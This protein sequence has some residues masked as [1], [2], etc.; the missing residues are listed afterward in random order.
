[1]TPRP[2]LI[3]LVVAVSAMLLV[4]P[5]APAD[6]HARKQATRKG[7]AAPHRA[8]AKRRA[9]KR[10][11]LSRTA[12]RRTSDHRAPFVADAA[13]TPMTAPAAL[14]PDD[15]LAPLGNDP[16]SPPK[17]NSQKVTVKRDH[18]KRITLTGDDADG[19]QFLEFAITKAPAHGTLSGAPPEVVYT[20][21]AGYLGPDHFVFK[22]SDGQGLSNS[23][24]VTITVVPLGAAPIVTTSAGCTAYTE[25]GPS[26]VVDGQVTVSDP[27]DVLLD[28]ARVRITTGFQGGDNLLFTDQNGIISSYD[29]NAGVLTLSGDATVAAYQAALSTVRYRNVAS[30]NANATKDVEFTVNDAGNDSAPAVKQVCVTGGAGGS[31]NRPVG[32]TSEGGLSYLENDGPLP[33]DSGFVVGDPDSTT[34]SGATVKFVPLVSQAVDEN[35][36]PVGPP[37]STATFAPGEDELAFVDQNGITGVYD[38]GTGLLTLSGP[39]S[40]ADYETA[41]RSV[42]YENSSEDPSDATRRIQFQL[43]DSSALNSTSVRRDVFITPVNDAP[44]VTT[45]AGVTDYTGSATAVDTG[46]TAIDVDD[47]DLESA[48]VRITSGLQDGDELAVAAPAG[49]ADAYD[50]TTGVLTLSGTASV[51]DYQTALRSIAFGHTGGDPSGARTV[52]YTI[53]DGELDSGTA[54]KDV[55]VNDPPVLATTSVDAVAY[56]ENDPAVAVDPGLTAADVDSPQLAGA[57]VAISS[58]FAAGEDVLAFADLGGITGAYDD[59][60]GVLTLSGAASP[61]DYA[62]A[63]QSV[64]YENSSEDPSGATRTVTFR[65]DDGAVFNSLSN[66]VTR[67][68]AVTPVN[69]AP[70]VVTSDG[71]TAA[72]EGD[73][74]VAVDGALTV[75]DVDSTSLESAQVSV[76]SALQAGDELSFTDQNGITGVY[77]SGVLSLSGTASVADYEAALRSVGYAHT[78]DDPVASKT[79]DFTAGDGEVSSSP[80]TKEL[81]VTGV[82]DKPSLD[83]SDT[84]LAYIGGDGAVAVDDAIAATDPDS[85]QLG[86]ATV[87]I[88]ANF[89]AAEDTLAFTDQNGITSAYDSTTGVLTLTGPASVAQFQAA[90]R[91]VTYENSSATPTTDTRTVSFQVD[92]G[93]A[94]DNL[95]DAA[96]RDVSVSAGNG[97]L[98]P[99]VTSSAGTT[100]YTIGDPPTALDAGVTVTDAD[101]AN[102]ESAVVRVATGFEAGDTLIFVAQAGITGLYDPLTGILTLSGTA[103]VAEYETALRSITYSYTGENPSGSRTVETK[104]NDG[105][106]NSNAGLRA[107]EINSPAG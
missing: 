54:S 59:T 106:R 4:P 1:M 55:E 23:G 88:T 66:E 83:T 37:T 69:D 32:E 71:S 31:A 11:T 39:A 12:K 107:L 92:D 96:T 43:T 57:T 102:L 33:V 27:D 62:L 90:L 6:T 58:G 73:P 78:G 2:T 48:V 97:D 9:H 72:T 45:S 13:A 67:D 34:L 70:Q 30:G 98:R 65:V 89:V 44:V 99:V 28:S 85:A 10:H 104:V 80:A 42:T 49:V 60:T 95:S 16:N 17:A 5:A 19:A 56:T 53:N 74:A 93:A 46:L 51:A 14:A 8:K 21:D 63:L 38:D 105:D 15:P 35:G 86:G 18:A 3:A 79:V 25:Q 24:Q 41:I 52:E 20:P 101:D 75:T 100:T 91:S 77:D 7:H 36:D 26:V 29:E 22:T 61:D 47:D 87:A 40:L 94:T 81:A 76:S 103:T 68:V 50:S 64:T 82:N 84:A